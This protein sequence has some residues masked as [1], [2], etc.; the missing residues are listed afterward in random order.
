LKSR[1]LHSL[2]DILLA[3]EGARSYV[4]AMTYDEFFE[5]GLIRDAVLH[6]L[7][8]IGEAANRIDKTSYGELPQLPWRDMIDLR[9]FVVHQYEDINMPTIWD[10]IQRDLP[11]VVTALDPLFPERKSR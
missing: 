7:T 5:N 1:D 9:N 2:L 4:G 11:V 10:V 6:C 3:A 8:V